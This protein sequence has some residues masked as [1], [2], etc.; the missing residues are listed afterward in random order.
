MAI[1]LCTVEFAGG[2]SVEF[3]ITAESL[4][5]AYEFAYIRIS[6]EGLDYEGEITGV[7]VD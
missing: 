5:Q 3:N 6:E 7:W 4:E 1:Y 2:C